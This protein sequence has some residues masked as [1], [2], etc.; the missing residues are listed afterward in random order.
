MVDLFMKWE[1]GSIDVM[2]M[3]VSSCQTIAKPSFRGEVH[4]RFLWVLGTLHFRNPPCVDHASWKSTNCLGEVEGQIQT[5]LE[6]SAGLSG[7]IVKDPT[8]TR[9]TQSQC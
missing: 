8:E 9:V 6:H 5:L 1:D 2:G 4:V 3:G 7:S